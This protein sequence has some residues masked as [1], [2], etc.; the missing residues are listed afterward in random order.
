MT[1]SA[2]D[3]ER[4][5][6]VSSFRD[7][8]GRVVQW[9]GRILRAINESGRPS[10]EVAQSS[11]IISALIEA[12]S[13]VETRRLEPAEKS[14]FL[15]SCPELVASSN[16]FLVE[17]EVIPFPS[18]PYEW[19][20]EMLYAAASLTLDM[21]ESLLEEGIGLKDGTPCN[22]L[23]RGV[24]PVFVDL[25]SVE[26]RRPDDPVWLPHAQF[27]RTF[28]LPLLATRRWHTPLS[29]IFLTHRDGL[30]PAD[31]YKRCGV[32]ER[33]HPEL[34]GL[35][36]VPAW[37]TAWQSHNG[38]DIY[39]PH[40]A[41]SPEQANFVLRHTFRSLR[42]KLKSLRPRPQHSA[43][44][45]YAENNSYSSADTEL[46]NAFVTSL[47]QKFRPKRVL[48]V[49]CN[50]GVYSMMAAQSGANVVA[51]D[52]DA[53]SV[54]ALFRA[55]S[56]RNLSILPMVVDMARPTPAMG[57]NNAEHPS[58]LARAAGAFDAVFMLAVLHHLL[59]T[60]RIPLRSIIDLAAKL[61][62]DLLVIEYVGRHDPMFQKLLRG[63]DSL[64]E[65][66]TRELFEQECDR[67]FRIVDSTQVQPDRWIYL[68]R[69]RA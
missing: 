37:L 24:Q 13:F 48:D 14:E 30:Y 6:T 9:R 66:F 21:C 60:E 34:F 40:K 47:M 23:F 17:H 45:S 2:T 27:V 10:F 63:R 20:A 43:W 50:T 35:V 39:H 42:K 25:L 55:A 53:A 19:P 36:S 46:K 28:L 31:V 32:L 22:V 5:E 62:T 7:P 67:R 54:G 41:S 4:S 61:T 58:F 65:S 44:S 56:E 33:F 16:A 69:R 8:C 51:I 18:Y 64:H 15:T 38:S 26:K 49:G 11:H 68:L 12:G 3:T 52:N 29:E 1:P 57:W 59:V